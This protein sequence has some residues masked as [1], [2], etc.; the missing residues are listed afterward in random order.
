MLHKAL[1]SEESDKFEL[2]EQTCLNSDFD[3]FELIA[4]E[5]ARLLPRL[6]MAV[7]FLTPLMSSRATP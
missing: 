6:R 5:T 3:H 4:L 2:A 7:Y 1:I